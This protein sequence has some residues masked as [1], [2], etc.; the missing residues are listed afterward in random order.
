MEY[1]GNGVS[2][3]DT[4][5]VLG[6]ESGTCFEGA[7]RVYVWDG[8]SWTLQQTIT[9]PN[10]GSGNVDCF[11]AATAVSGDT[12]FIGAPAEGYN[13]GANTGVVYEY[14]RSGTTWTEAMTTLNDS[15]DTQFGQALAFDGTHLAVGAPR[16]SADEGTLTYVGQVEILVKSTGGGGPGGGGWT[17]QATVA[18][19]T[20]VQGRASGRRWRSAELASRWGPAQR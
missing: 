14:R 3:D 15:G 9:G 5:I 4:T 7:A 6:N 13:G 20:A 11:G 12:A 2:I 16:A 18:P 8:A 10:D 19:A 17:T 1:T